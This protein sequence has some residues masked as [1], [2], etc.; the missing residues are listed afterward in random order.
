MNP[1]YGANGLCDR[2]QSFDV[3]GALSTTGVLL[4]QQ[5]IP[6]PATKAAIDAAARAGVV[7][8]FLIRRLFV[9]FLMDFMIQLLCLLQIRGGLY[10]V[11]Y[12]GNRCRFRQIRRFSYS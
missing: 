2:Q 3:R 10:H 9:R 6:L 7:V 4:C 8:G 1:V 5:E 11:G 12:W